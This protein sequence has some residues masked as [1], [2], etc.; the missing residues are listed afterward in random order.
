MTEQEPAGK[1]ERSDGA[2]AKS[3]SAA[4]TDCRF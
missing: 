3:P 1:T 4:Q 2:I